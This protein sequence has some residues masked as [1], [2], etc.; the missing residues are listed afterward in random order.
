M[1][2]KVNFLTEIILPFIKNK[3][4][5]EGLAKSE[6]P[7]FSIDKLQCIIK[8]DEREIQVGFNT[9]NIVTDKIPY[10]GIPRGLLG[11]QAFYL[12]IENFWRNCVKHNFKKINEILKSNNIYLYININDKPRTPFL[13]I[14]LWSNVSNDGDVAEKINE[15]L[16]QGVI[17]SEGKMIFEGW[18]TKEMLIGATFLRGSPLIYVNTKAKDILRCEMKELTTTEKTLCYK[19]DMLKPMELFIS[20]S[21]NISNANQ[22]KI[23]Q[24]SSQ[25]VFVKT[26]DIPQDFVIPTEYFVKVD[27]LNKDELALQEN[28]TAL[29][30]IKSFSLKGDVNKLVNE[31]SNSEKLFEFL[32]KLEVE[33]IKKLIGD[34]N[35]KILL[36]IRAPVNE[37]E[38]KAWQNVPGLVNNSDELKNLIEV[39]VLGTSEEEKNNLSQKINEEIKKNSFIIIFDR[40]GELKDQV[41]SIKDKEIF[42]EPYSSG[43][44]TAFILSYL[45]SGEKEKILSVLKII[46]SSILKV[47]IIDERI[48]EILDMGDVRWKYGGGSKVPEINPIDCLK[49]MR[50]FV[51]RISEVNLKEPKEEYIKWILSVKPHILSIHAGVLDKMG[52]KTPE[53]TKEF[54][55]KLLQDMDEKIKR[56][57]IHSG[58]G[59]PSNVP[60]LSVPFISFTPVE[61]YTTSKDLKSK[62]GIVEELIS[63]RGIKR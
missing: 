8:Y 45:P 61:F 33:F 4:L 6:L 2:R 31:L 21:Q 38:W 44:K 35:K 42:W 30:P 13:E 47:A 1:V 10:V 58:R 60:N 41:I 22:E 63:A 52:K 50:I 57:V 24:L 28:T 62:C 39:L 36:L 29:Q 49:L 12:I 27:S 55:N 7:K 40:H 14:E 46:T 5:I 53:E 15:I 16:E 59:I 43:T 20:T 25:G 51:P 26:G 34:V 19:F 11:I 9:E 18:G 37:P 48:Q 32:I 23:K 17:S 3:K 54:I 56:V